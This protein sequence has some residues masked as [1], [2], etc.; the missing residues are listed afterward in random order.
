MYKEINP[1]E[2]TAGGSVVERSPSTRAVWVRFPADIPGQ[3]PYR[4]KGTVIVR[5]HWAGAA[6][7]MVAEPTS[8][9][10]EILLPIE[11]DKNMNIAFSPVHLRMR[12]GIKTQLLLSTRP[13]TPNF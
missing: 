9:H 12:G 3:Q 6:D 8:Q 11:A 7:L 2:F 4:V 10:R 5:S 13:T 1:P